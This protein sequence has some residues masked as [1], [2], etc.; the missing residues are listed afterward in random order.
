[1]LTGLALA[2]PS[3]EMVQFEISSALK[4]SA[5]AWNRGDLVRFMEDYVESE[6]LTFTAGGKVVRGYEALH[7]R[8]QK[9]Y[10]ND[11]DSMGQLQ[12][13][14]IEVWKLGQ[15]HALALGRWHLKRTDQD[16]VEGVFSLVFER[17]K[18]G[19]KIFHDHT[20]RLEK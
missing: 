11:K 2:E 20:S 12:F 8:Y 13:S 15:G 4:A 9:T 18:D 16:D 14:D 19:W 5:K 3:R 6:D 17:Q 1:M 7:Q 10:G